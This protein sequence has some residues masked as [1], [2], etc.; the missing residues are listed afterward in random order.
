[1]AQAAAPWAGRVFFANQ[2]NW[3]NPAAETAVETAFAA[4]R[5]VELRLARG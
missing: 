5:A 1:V 2:D 4:A 3:A